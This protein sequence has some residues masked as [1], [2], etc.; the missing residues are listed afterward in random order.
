MA[1]MQLTVEVL[2]EHA[3]DLRERAELSRR[4]PRRR[5]RVRPATPALNRSVTIRPAGAN[6]RPALRRLAALDDAPVPADP[7]LLAEVD[8]VAVAAM[9]VEDGDSVADPFVLTASLVR[10]LALRARQLRAAGT[11]GLALSRAAVR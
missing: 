10:L 7:V 2:A 1:P 9:S 3:R 5:R 6:D 11:G 4:A 8:G